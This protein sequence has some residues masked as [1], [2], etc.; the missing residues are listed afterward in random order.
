MSSY[1]DHFGS[2]LVATERRSHWITMATGRRAEKKE[3]T[4]GIQG[5]GESVTESLAWR[6][7]QKGVGESEEEGRKKGGKKKVKMK[8]VGNPR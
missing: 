7:K 5:K 4:R 8:V 2:T 3:E 1:I 6:S